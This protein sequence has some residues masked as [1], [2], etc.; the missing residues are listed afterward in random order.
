MIRIRTGAETLST[1]GAFGFAVSVKSIY[2]LSKSVALA[3]I[4]GSSTF[5]SLINVSALEELHSYS[6][7][8]VISVLIILILGSLAQISACSGIVIVGGTIK[9]A[10]IVSE[11]W[12]DILPVESKAIHSGKGVTFKVSVTEPIWLSCGLYIASNLSVELISNEPGP[13]AVH[14]IAL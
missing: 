8:F 3:V 6:S 9:V 5:V 10:T 7:A 4:S 1:Q 2:P 13:V 12:F 14:S 11:I